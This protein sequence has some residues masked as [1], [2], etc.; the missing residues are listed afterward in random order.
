MS[1]MSDK[2]MQDELEFMAAMDVETA[3]FFAQPKDSSS[4]EEKENKANPASNVIDMT[5]A[6]TQPS[7][8]DSK[9]M[10]PIPPS[11]HND[12]NDDW[13]IAQA[14]EESDNDE[15]DYPDE[16]DDV[17]PKLKA[18][19]TTTTTTRAVAAVA[20]VAPA[21]VTISQ[22]E[23]AALV[24][25]AAMNNSAQTNTTNTHTSITNNN[26][27]KQE[28]ETQLGLTAYSGE[29]ASKSSGS[30]KF[31]AGNTPLETLQNF[32]MPSFRAG[33]EKVIQATLAGRDSA[34][35]WATGLGKSLCYQI[36]ALHS[37]KTA[38]IVSPLISLM[39]DQ[40]IKL[41]NLC[42]TNVATFLGSGQNDGSADARA[43]RGEY[44]LVYLTPEKI[45]SDGFL[46]A[47]ASL[48]NR[49]GGLSLVAVDEAHC[50]SE[51]GH[52]FRPAFRLLGKIRECAELRSVPI[53]A[54][55]ATAVPRVQEDICNSLR[56]HA[57]EKAVSSF[58]RP[59]LRLEV[60]RKPKGGKAIAMT[61]LVK[62]MKERP[63]D[64]STIVY[65]PTT[66]DVDSVAELL[67]AQLNRVC[68][69]M[70]YHAKLSP[71]AREDAH[72]KFLSGEV[73]IIVATVAF[74]MGIDKPDTRRVIHWGSPK[75]VEEYYQQVGR[76]GRDGLSAECTM[77]V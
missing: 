68:K 24:R 39:Q 55:T 28:V 21:T 36:P 69:V 72:K 76:A 30:S 77:Y 46:S 16:V 22:E 34:V 25:S 71:S 51:W 61:K 26:A 44:L 48:H 67:A 38:F 63:L 60:F 37:G 14:E 62:E 49:G 35:F 8:G 6:K 52:D 50:V 45:T 1:A 10:R 17:K 19:T 31:R 73:Q 15:E 11:G 12:N 59:N 9:T 20:A 3:G 23:Y 75:T 58:D 42:N 56:M 66:A 57:P 65:A 53:M 18:T 41:N 54:L 13:M 47:M 27:W 43:L 40:C 74:G 32:G 7:H 5:G 4:I 29:A 70:P 2:E 33:Q 64:N